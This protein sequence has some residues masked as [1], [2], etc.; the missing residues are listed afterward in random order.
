MEQPGVEEG[1][2]C[3]EDGSEMVM[4]QDPLERRL[5]HPPYK[6]F[7]LDCKKIVLECEE[8]KWIRL[9]YDSETSGLMED[10]KFISSISNK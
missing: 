8:M 5:S 4:T 3:N 6:I 7:R 2:I 9:A 1:G 10:E